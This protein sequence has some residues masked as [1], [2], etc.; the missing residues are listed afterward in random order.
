M[1]PRCPP[2]SN[3]PAARR[4]STRPARWLALVVSWWIV[5]AGH[6]WAAP[7]SAGP[8]TFVID[9]TITGIGT[10]SPSGIV[11]VAAGGTQTFTITPAACNRVAAVLVDG[12]SVGAVSSYTF[13][14]VQDDH[15]FDVY[16]AFTSYAIQASANAG[17]T[18]APA[19]TVTA[20][21]QS[22][23]TFTIAPAFG[24]QLD[25]VLVDGVA[26]GAVTSY[27]FSNIAANHS[28]AAQFV[29]NVSVTLLTT[30]PNPSSC[31]Q[32]VTLHANVFPTTATGTVK[33]IDGGST[34]ATLTLAH[35]V[36]ESVMRLSV[37]THPLTARYSGDQAYPPSASA[38]MTQVV[39]V[40]TP[41]T[42][43]SSLNPSV[44]GHT[45]QLTA[46]TLPSLVAAIAF[47][48]GGTSLGTVP[49]A[50][51]VAVK[52]VAPLTGT[53]AF[54]AQIV[55]ADCTNGQRSPTLTQTVNAPPPVT[56]TVSSSLNPSACGTVV[57]LTAL[58]NTTDA[59]GLVVFYDNGV[60]LTSVALANGAAAYGLTPTLGQHQFA[61][62]YSGDACH[63][64]TGVSS[65]ALSQTVNGG[66][67]TSTKIAAVPRNTTCG[68]PVTLTATIKP[69]VS[70]GRVTFLDGGAV[71]GGQPVVGGTAS[72][73]IFPEAGS[74][75]YVAQYTGDF[76]TAN[77]A[78]SPLSGSVALHAVSVAL[79]S[80][81]SPSACGQPFV[82]D[83]A[84]TPSGAAGTVSFFEGATLVG[85]GS[86]A[87]GHALLTLARTAGVHHFTARYN[88]DGC[89]ASATSADFAQSVGPGG[90]ALGG[91]AVS[92]SPNP[93]PVGQ[94][95]RFTA[96][97]SPAY[98]TGNVTFYD[99]PTPM[100]SAALANG[101]AAITVSTLA[102]NDH[103]ITA[104]Y[105]GDACFTPAT[106]PVYTE[107]ITL[108]PSTVV[109]TATPNPVACAQATTLTASMSPDDATGSV[110]FL[111][112][113]INLGRASVLGGQ[114][115]LTTKL[116]GLGVHGLTA[117]YEGSASYLPSTG[118]ASVTVQGLT[119]SIGVAPDPDP[120][121]YG[122]PLTLHATVFPAVM[123]SIVFF[124]SLT[125]LGVAPLAAGA[126][127]LTVSTLA[128]GWHTRVGGIL[129]GDSCTVAV[130]TSF[131]IS[132]VRARLPSTT[133]LSSTANPSPF[134]S[135][136]RLR[137]TVLPVGSVGA[138]DFFDGAQLL[139]T[140]TPNH[141]SGIA[142]LATDALAPGTH[143]LSAQFVGDEYTLPSVSAIYTQVIVGDTSAV[144]LA[145][146][147]NPAP[148]GAMVTFTATVTPADATGVVELLDGGSSI[149][150]ME[151]AGGVA[152]FLVSDLA[153][154]THSM[155]AAYDG[156]GTVAGSA[157]PP[158]VQQITGAA[159]LA[160]SR[161]P[162]G[163]APREAL[164]DAP[165]LASAWPNPTTGALQVRYGLPRAM[166]VRLS[167]VD[168]AGREVRVLAR[169]E[170]AAGWLTATWDGRDGSGRAAPGLYFVRLATPGRVV[171][172]RVA[173]AN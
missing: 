44:C 9:A 94:P 64:A 82:L 162:P 105:A 71:V 141:T 97:V 33:I 14:N 16:I 170:G 35:G 108:R 58:A 69:A 21:C 117:A 130:S 129:M 30:T 81:P 8:G 138:V 65:P 140:T 67:A 87:S 32:L 159:A 10:L 76:C 171:V 36:A 136:L 152:T 111:D 118:A 46:T 62:S 127:S 167:V 164:P 124:D 73:T 147:P 74:H 51:G 53:H 60:S 142:T 109:L 12:V 112:G 38:T 27:T 57:T 15:T 115:R 40:V 48:D 24:D 75:S 11:S 102:T 89:D 165:R 146:T 125:T 52:S 163:A 55:S 101:S 92:A 119:P 153:V 131:A 83:A 122:L 155:Q 137:A 104:T 31:N 168:V 20:D 85:S 72:A 150:S 37:G 80:S 128:P 45:V 96:T 41:F 133:T 98:A 50:N 68:T 90:G 42:L 18:I 103:A 19:G 78:S 145:S 172:A 43:Q 156:M 79:T 77:S 123:G 4:G 34:L 6:A 49:L 161:P 120:A 70:I 144:A 173:V 29:P 23:L 63:A 3:L 134:G 25:D 99:G 13:T 151:L 121:I 149:A 61:V 158:Y 66:T 106:S 114:A 56:L 95:V 157:S 139:G 132:V 22:T 100:G 59:S 86:V 54:T 5:I 88:S 39:Q 107:T 169:G 126:A 143:A 84:V 7:S 148:H 166:P 154:G 47:F 110:T 160:A 113:A 2:A 116:S 91:V 1:T 93:C 135:L 28:I 17:G 26:V